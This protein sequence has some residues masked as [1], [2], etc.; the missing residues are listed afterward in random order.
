[1]GRD[2]SELFNVKK[3]IIGMIHLAGRDEKE[4]IDRALEE[5]S[6]FE[7]EGVSGAIVEDYHGSIED[8]RNVLKK[9]S[10]RKMKLVVGVNA[11]GH[12]CLGFNLADEFGAGFIQFDS[13]QTRDLDLAYYNKSREKY[14]N[15]C[16]L[17]G[18]RFKYKRMT[19]NS[20]EEDLAEGMPR[21][22]AVVTTGEGTGIETP[23]E[24]LRDFKRILGSFPLVVG[25]GV[26]L[27]NVY[28]QLEIADG[29]IVG[30][31]F[32]SYDTNEKVIRER[33]S[34]LMSEV[35]NRF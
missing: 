27:K 34:E 35:K 7:E 30:S 24:K 28:E 18:I 23:T 29:A 15:I 22:D 3:P 13:V 16:V 20:L 17:G 8:I 19:G 9:T 12:P 31:Y 26:N 25:A 32:K 10:R 21:C 11:L 4:K 6:I 14:P 5:I 1:M 2:F 33:V